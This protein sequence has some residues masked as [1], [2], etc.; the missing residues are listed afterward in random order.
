MSVSFSV[1]VIQV[2]RR[3]RKVDAIE[4]AAPD[5]TASK[6]AVSALSKTVLTQNGANSERC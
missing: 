6:G 2:S 1:N 5:E 4:K 3:D